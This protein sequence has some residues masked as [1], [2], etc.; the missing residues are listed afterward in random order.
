VLWTSDN[1]DNHDLKRFLSAQ[2]GVYERALSEL[3]AGR[4]RTHWMWYIFPQIDGLG[5][6]MTARRY[7]IKSVDEARAYLGHP[8]LGPRLLRCAEAVLALEGRSVS[9]IFGSPDDLKLR[10]CMTL[11]AR[12]AEPGSVFNRVLKKYYKGVQDEKTLSILENLS[13]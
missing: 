9:E 8:V 6:S 5:W 1:P 4:K 2:E 3:R 11:F 7:A 12:V 10:S 13:E